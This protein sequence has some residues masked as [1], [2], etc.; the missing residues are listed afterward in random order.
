MNTYIALFRGINV[1]GHNK[2]PMKELRAL[3]DS[4]GY[5]NVDSYIQ[6][7]N[8]IFQTEKSDKKKIAGNISSG[9]ENQHGFKPDVLLLELEEFE[10]AIAS[11]PFPQAVAKPKSLH[12]MFLASPPSNPDLESLEEIKNNSERFELKDK[13]F[14]LHTPDGFGRSKLAGKTEKALGVSMT[15]RNWRTVQK[16][17][18]MAEKYN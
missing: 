10:K 16:I 8:V 18:E 17:S 5:Q 9:I 13:V 12:L 11:N 1:G 7:G 14:Y 4:F 2:L 6:T 3:L 15:G